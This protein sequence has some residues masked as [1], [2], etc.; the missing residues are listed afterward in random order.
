MMSPI[1][2]GRATT[3]KL[4]VTSKPIAIAQPSP[5]I[6][7]RSVCLVTHHDPEIH[8]PDRCSVRPNHA[9]RKQPI[10]EA[11]ELL[12]RVGTVGFQYVTPEQLPAPLL[13]RDPFHL[14]FRHLAKEVHGGKAR[15][16]ERSVPVGR[17]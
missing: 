15:S 17:A 1:D 5:I 13:F 9:F 11:P 10:A 7:P 4:K 3:A 14:V 16:G 6:R 2:S 8:K 12:A